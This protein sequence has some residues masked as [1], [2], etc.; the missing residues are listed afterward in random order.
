MFRITIFQK[1][2]PLKLHSNMNIIYSFRFLKKRPLM[3]FLVTDLK[4]IYT[5]F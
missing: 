4:R 5:T 1:E 2:T 3:S